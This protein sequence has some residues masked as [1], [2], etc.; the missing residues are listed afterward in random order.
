MPAFARTTALRLA[1]YA[2]VVLLFA[3]LGALIDLAFHPGIPYFDG[4]HLV[5]GAVTALAMVVLLA[6]LEVYLRQ[7]RR[8]EAA[9][10]ESESRYR[11]YF[12][13]PLV[14]VMV[15]SPDRSLVEVNQAA[16]D[17]LGYDRDELLSLTWPDLTHPDD[18]TADRVRNQSLVA[19]EA[20]STR[21]EKRFIRKDGEVVHADMSLSCQRRADGSVDYFVAL[22]SDVTDQR[23]SAQESALLKH[24][25]DVH[26]DGAFWMGPDNTFVYVNEAACAM[27]GYSRSE[28]IGQHLSL[29]SPEATPERLVR[30]WE[31]LRTEG[32]LTAETMHRRKDGSEFPVQITSSY[33]SFGGR[34][35][36]CGFA[37]DITERRGTENALLMFKTA[38]DEATYGVALADRDGL[39]TYVNAAAAAMHGWAPDELL[40]RPVSLFHN[41]EQ[42][43]RFRELFGR[44][45]QEG[46]FSL[47]EVWHTRRDGSVF[48]ALMSATRIEGIAGQPGFSAVTMVDIT[49]RV[50]T[51]EE[52]RRAEERYARAQAIGHLGHWEYDP[53]ARAFRGSAEVV[54]L[55]GLD[56]AATCH[57]AE[58]VLGC[59]CEEEAVRRAFVDLLEHHAPFDMEL[60]IDPADGAAVRIVWVFAEVERDDEGSPVR[61]T[62]ILQDTTADRRADEALRESKMMR[63]VAEHVARIGSLKWALGAADSAWSPEVYELFDIHPG[64]FDGDL[65]CALEARVHPD[66][67]E[68][69]VRAAARVVELGVLPVREFRIVRRD[70]EE[71]IIQ[72][73][74][75]GERDA[76]G[77]VTALIGYV[78]DVTE[79]RRAEAEIKQLNAELEQR[80]AERTA[81]LTTAN[82]E[83][84]AFAYA[85]SHDLRAP[86]RAIDGF[87]Q[88]IV[89][90]ESESLS[91]A[92]RE[93]LVRVRTAAQ[94]MGQLID[95]LLAL[96]RLSRQELNL[97]RVDLS[98]SATGILAG[99]REQEPGRQVEACV[100][101][102]CTAVSDVDLVDAVLTNL[103]GNAW[104][105]TGAR[106]AASI[107]F[108]ETHVDGERVFY[109]RDDG[110]GFDPACADKL[111]QPFQ[112][113]H[114]AD[115]FPGTGIGLATVRRIVT[116]LGGRC[117]A[118]GAPDMGAT[119]Y[120]TL[121]EPAEAG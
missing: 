7:R 97:G 72:G 67:L 27:L 28:L 47:E 20:G 94:R 5:E 38:A 119:F 36:N 90:D 56:P 92:G 17:L 26:R 4:E 32:S 86:L 61:V 9:L 96:S 82:L 59:I 99:L 112:R 24:S 109:V 105:F 115:Q 106:D 35:Y 46:G 52:L 118:E 49:E 68:H 29:V 116:R 101:A 114:A 31:R 88:I 60:E 15:A 13:Q 85:V 62:G 2:V 73:A 66:D 120:F 104:K 107:E 37:L 23:R 83:L 77:A 57:T 41:E 42:T 95:A 91:E 108:G 44:V 39:F 89:E 34:E 64:E 12:E 69:L 75:T 18:V 10:G 74:G 11:G 48:P 25:I 45:L 43:G 53:K 70:G 100:A 16:C 58:E 55:C 33:V 113:L 81:Q 76:D 40:G 14:G 93:N 79:R 78:Q 63:D 84:E 98:A 3:N 80:V 1:L 30:I 21:F 110:A 71:R 22:I 102:G 8:A 51:E 6:A 50:H 54:R 103:L 121:P 111:F 87:S 117:W 65:L 19:G